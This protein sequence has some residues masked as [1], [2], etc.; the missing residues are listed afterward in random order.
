MLPSIERGE[1]IK[2]GAEASVY[3]AKWQGYHCVFKERV[4]KNYRSPQLDQRLRTS[5]TRKEARLIHQLKQTGIRVPYLYH[6]DTLEC[7]IL[8]EFLKGQL[9]KDALLDAV[10]TEDPG[11]VAGLLGSLGRL[12]GA[13]HGAGFIHGDLT[14]SNVIVL[15]DK[16]NKAP[17]PLA[18]VDLGLGYKSKESED[19]GV[20]LHV[21]LEAFESTHSEILEQRKLILEAYKGTFS[22]A[23]EV[24]AKVEEIE[25]RGRYR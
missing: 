16:G 23:A 5:R 9:L 1:L 2:Q 21:L 7:S 6:I 18:L 12:V 3:E 22:Q 10:K 4:P 17:H 24:L 11:Q 13:L 15:E 8:M 25:R 14:T 20:D 19:R